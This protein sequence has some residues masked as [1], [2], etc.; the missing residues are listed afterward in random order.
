MH[1]YTLSLTSALDWGLAALSQERSG[2]LS[3]GGC[4]GRVSGLD[5]SEK[6]RPTGIQSPDRPARGDSL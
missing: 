1:S 2:T 6:S 3:I 4:L 5:E